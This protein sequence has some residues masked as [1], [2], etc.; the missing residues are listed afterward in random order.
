MTEQLGEGLGPRDEQLLRDVADLRLVTGG[1]LQRLAFAGPDASSTNP[2][3]ARRCL[4][5]LTD[6]GL[7]QRLERRVGG[8]RAGSSSYVYAISPS[9]ATAIGKRLGR[10]QTSQP[11]L[12]FLRHQLAVAD[13]F[14]ALR[15]AH[16]DGQLEALTIDTEPKCWRPLTDGS[17]GVLKPDLFVVAARRSDELLTFIEVDNGTEH[18]AALGRKLALYRSHYD[19][20]Q[21]Q[22]REGVFPEVL[23][24]SDDDGRREQLERAFGR[25]QQPAGLHRALSTSAAINY[26]TKGGD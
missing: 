21:E 8:I 9:G 10:G 15:R 13:V 5:R 2:R 25:S 16:G 19:S 24:L 6:Q 20:G 7:L 11:S 23:W 12:I 1:Q 17:G 26:I 4:R 3:I 14:V 18:A 22:S